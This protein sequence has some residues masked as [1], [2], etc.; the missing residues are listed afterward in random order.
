MC[1]WLASDPARAQSM[2]SLEPLDASQA[3]PHAREAFERA[4]AAAPQDVDL[5]TALGVIA[6]L[7][8]DFRAATQA[9]E[10]ALAARPDEYSLW[11]K[12]GA[13]L[14][15]SNRSGDAKAAYFRALQLKPSYMRAWANLGISHGNLG[16]Y[17][18]AAGHYI[19]ALTL[20]PH[21][22]G[23]WGYLKTAV[24][25]M[26]RMDLVGIVDAKDIGRLTAELG[27]ADLSSMVH[28]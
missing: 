10:R 8:G 12:L 15:N 24:V 21:A 20:N 16:Q 11:N 7:S 5:Q 18:D 23:V 22:E 2:V 3:L 4:A 28:T 27:S 19:K 6:H 17:T 1:R 14:A 9:F 26:G 25:L 13:T